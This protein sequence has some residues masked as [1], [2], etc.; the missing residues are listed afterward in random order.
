MLIILYIGS[1]VLVWIS[2]FKYMYDNNKRLKKEGY[3]FTSKRRFRKGDII[4][5]LLFAILLSI[6][7]ANLIIPLSSRDKERAYDEYKNML[8][9]SGA[10]EEPE[11]DEIKEVVKE[12]KEVKIINNINNKNN[13]K[14]VYKPLYRDDNEIDKGGYTYKKVL[15]RDKK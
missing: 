4:I 14:E 6:P 1:T 2:T 15:F 13:E 11:I 9:E 12:V 7:V 3:I 10:I 5:G 8:L